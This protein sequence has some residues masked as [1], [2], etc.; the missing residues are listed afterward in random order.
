MY[1]CIIVSKL[2]VDE[3]INILSSS[4]KTK[5]A[6]TLGRKAYSFRFIQ[7]TSVQVF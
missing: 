5:R 6:L 2:D 1:E 3:M 7:I 4:S